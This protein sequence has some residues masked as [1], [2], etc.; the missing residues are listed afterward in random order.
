MKKNALLISMLLGISILLM[1]G[2]RR[3]DLYVYYLGPNTV[4]YENQE[5][6][7]T[8]AT[9]KRPGEINISDVDYTIYDMNWSCIET[10]KLEYYPE[11]DY[12]AGEWVKVQRIKSENG[13]TVFVYFEKNETEYMRRIDVNMLPYEQLDSGIRVTQLPAGVDEQPEW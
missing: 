9:K 11:G 7:Y 6:S 1:T 4:T 10:G 8:K 2:C 12:Y 13:D 5:V 3:A